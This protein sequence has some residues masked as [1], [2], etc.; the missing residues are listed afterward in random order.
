VPVVG[1]T[2]LVPMIP[3]LYTPNG[4]LT[5]IGDDRANTISV[6]SSGGNISVLGKSFKASEVKSIV[7]A[8]EGGDDTIKVGLSVTAPTVLYGGSGNDTISAGGGK[9]TVY[10][11]AGN[12]KLVGGPLNDAFYTGR[13]SDSVDG[14][15]G[16]DSVYDASS[17]DRLVSASGNVGED[18]ER[19]AYVKTSFTGQVL[20]EV[21]RLVNAER[22]RRGLRALALDTAVNS[23]ASNLAS[24]LA[25]L[26]VPVGLGISHAFSGYNRPTLGARFDRNLLAVASARENNGFV[27][28]AGVTAVTL[29]SEF[30]Y[31]ISG[32]GGLMNSAGHKANILATDVDRI[33]LGLAGSS[34]SGYYL[35]QDFAKLA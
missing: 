17:S 8:G 4:I 11:G 33:G 12:D 3:V 20:N 28:H 18:P 5:V 22:T 26:S 29:A 25:S 9:A 31:G 27:K 15:A 1:V 23:V 2:G 6:T 10:G 32:K 7:I 19:T 30:M 14:A 24:T 16:S 35:S 34:G 13:G 21:L